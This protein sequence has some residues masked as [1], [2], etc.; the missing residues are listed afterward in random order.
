MNVLLVGPSGAGKTMIGAW[1][2][3]ELGLLWFEADVWNADGITRH[4]LR[5]QW[6]AFYENENPR[7]LGNTLSLRAKKNNRAGTMLTLPSLVILS[8]AHVE[9]ATEHGLTVVIAWGTMENCVDA[10][11]IRERQHPRG[12]GVNHWHHFNDACLAE[13][14]KSGYAPLRLETFNADG[15]RRFRSDIMRELGARR[16]DDRSIG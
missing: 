13:Y 2:A 1:A 9:A 7:R 10:F 3:E 14:A 8:P 16:R 5:A 15:S 4:R 12:I 6:D 11:N